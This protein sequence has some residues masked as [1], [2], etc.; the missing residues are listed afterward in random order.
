M[1]SVGVQ[2]VL[3][4]GG[5]CCE[6]TGCYGGIRS[7]MKGHR[8][9][10]N[11]SCW[12]D[13]EGDKDRRQ[14]A[15]GIDSGEELQTLLFLHIVP[16]AFPL[17]FCIL[18]VDFKVKKMVVD[19]HTVQLAI[20]VGLIWGRCGNVYRGCAANNLCAV[21]DTQ[22]ML[23]F[24]WN[25]GN[26]NAVIY[27]LCEGFVAFTGKLKQLAPTAGAVLPACGNWEIGVQDVF[28]FTCNVI[29]ARSVFS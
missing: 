8:V 14:S 22:Q 25:G 16:T 4:M 24:G 15:E 29:K 26:K 9:W 11:G 13:R 18:G 20:W 6:G 23:H 27:E 1:G 5:E 10:G 21:P 19:G 17:L 28:R 3:W 2:R 12:G 7:A